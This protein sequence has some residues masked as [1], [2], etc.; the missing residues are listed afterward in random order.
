MFFRVGREGKRREVSGMNGWAKGENR[1]G[2]MLA[3]VGER[4]TTGVA[5]R[6]R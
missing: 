1:R 3:C 4:W 2:E 6:G 5:L